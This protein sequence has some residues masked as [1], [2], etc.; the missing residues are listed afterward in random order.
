MKKKFFWLGLTVLATGFALSPAITKLIKVDTGKSEI[1]WKCDKHFG[2]FPLDSG[3][4]VV[5]GEIIRDGMF[6]IGVKDIYVADL[7]SS[8]YATAKMILENTLKNEF[9]EVEKYPENYFHLIEAVPEENG[10]YLVEGD[11]N[12]H[13]NEV[14]VKFSA[15]LKKDKDGIM[16]LESEKFKIDR[17]D[18]GIYRLSPK[19]PYPDD[20]HGW[21]VP[22]TVEI[23]VKLKFHLK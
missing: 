10:K 9:L 3:Q 12:L 18:W 16:E 2:F 4:V 19:N 5:E 6:Y 21:T 7:D 22:D 15:G 1:Y 11:L 13:G 23:Q 17:T 20:E 8:H 14:C